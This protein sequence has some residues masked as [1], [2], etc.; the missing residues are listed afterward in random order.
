M[1]IFTFC[2]HSTLHIL[3]NRTE[4]IIFDG[5]EYVGSTLPSH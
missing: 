4:D 3:S 1:K 2:Y 5:K